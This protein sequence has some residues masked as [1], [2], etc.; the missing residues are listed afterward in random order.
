MLLH[1]KTIEV[2]YT[3]DEHKDY[4][5]RL[6]KFLNP[7]NDPNITTAMWNKCV[8]L[9][10]NVTKFYRPLTVF[11]YDPLAESQRCFAYSSPKATDKNNDLTHY[12]LP[13]G[14]KILLNCVILIPTKKLQII[15]FPK[16]IGMAQSQ[17]LKRW[18]IETEKDFKFVKN[19]SALI[20]EQY[21]T[22][23]YGLEN[24]KFDSY[25]VQRAHNK[26]INESKVEEFCKKELELIKQ[27]ESL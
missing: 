24:I 25:D 4:I 22:I 9:K 11:D 20:L 3:P 14:T 7:K 21:K 10:G 2:L 8:T 1:K 12:S 27:Q 16:E 17:Q 6:N 5:E 13:N 19:K 23:K 15:D 26:M 18:L